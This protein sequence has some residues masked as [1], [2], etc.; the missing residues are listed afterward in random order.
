MTKAYNQLRG[1]LGKLFEAEKEAEAKAKAKR[2]AEAKAKAKTDTADKRAG[3]MSD[4]VLLAELK[5][6]GLI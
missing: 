2:E 4:A 5:K 6:R 1:I 3:D